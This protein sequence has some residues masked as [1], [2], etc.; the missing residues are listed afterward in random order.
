[1]KKIVLQAASFDGCL[2]VKLYHEER[3]HQ[4]KNSVL[5]FPAPAPLEPGGRRG[6]RCQERLGGLFRYYR[7]DA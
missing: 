4:G 6:I 5:L 2:G 3:N 7:R 1:M